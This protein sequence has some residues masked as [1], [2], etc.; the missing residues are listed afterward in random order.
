MGHTFASISHLETYSLAMRFVTTL[1]RFV[2]GT[3]CQHPAVA[4]KGI[5]ILSSGM[6]KAEERDRTVVTASKPVIPHLLC[7]LQCSSVD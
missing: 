1:K 3:L 7:V 6:H 4:G 2:H 5:N